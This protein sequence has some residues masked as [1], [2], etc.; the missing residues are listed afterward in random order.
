MQDREELSC[1]IDVR[2][3]HRPVGL[4]AD[5]GS[6]T[7]PTTSPVVHTTGHRWPTIRHF[8]DWSL[9][10]QSRLIL[11][12]M[13]VLMLT[14]LLV[15]CAWFRFA[16]Q[17]SWRQ[18]GRHKNFLWFIGQSIACQSSAWFPQKQIILVSC[19]MTSSEYLRWWRVD[20]PDFGSSLKRG[21]HAS[22][23][24]PSI[25]ADDLVINSSYP[26]SLPA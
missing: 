15:L 3:V 22:W 7:W 25:T 12:Q 19:Q 6:Q 21:D 24:S 9:W 8:P 20:C 26:T 2:P 4:N 1:Q 16:R 5:V 10:F 18:E 14:R 17:L 23:H 13:S 11:I